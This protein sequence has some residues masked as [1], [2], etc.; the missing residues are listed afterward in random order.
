M[1]E[2]WESFQKIEH[3]SAEMSYTD[4]RTYIQRIQ[5]SGYDATRYLVGL[6]SKLSLPLLNLI[7]VLIGIPFA[8]RTSRSRRRGLKRWHQRDD[9]FCFWRHL[10]H[11]HF[12]RKNGGSYPLPICLDPHCPLWTRGHLHSDE[13]QTIT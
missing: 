12:H 5:A 6:Y 2:T 11:L 4:L 7:M 9:R 10:L 8:L 13:Y 1:D 3:A